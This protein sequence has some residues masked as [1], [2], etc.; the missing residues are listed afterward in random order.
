[1]EPGTS[2]R[3]GIAEDF[4]R[5]G[6]VLVPGVFEEAE[7]LELAEHVLHVRQPP[8]ELLAKYNVEGFDLNGYQSLADF[9]PQ[10]ISRVSRMLRLHL[11]D[12]RTRAL[13]LDPRLFDLM[14]ALWP[15]E[16]LA[17]HALYFPKPPGGRGLAL[18]SDLSYLPVDP[19]DLAGCFIAVDEIDAENGAL[20]VVPGSHRIADFERRVITYDESIVPEEFV[21]PAGTELVTVAMHPGDV[22]LFHGGCLHGSRPNRRRDRWRRAFTCHYVSGAARSVSE[23]LNPA[24]RS[25]G[26]EIPAPGNLT[27]AHPR[28]NPTSA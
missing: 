19:P 25:T 28:M 14:R 3:S 18:H 8:P 13:M 6:F 21:Q 7:L 1:M 26:E 12:D 9:E 11:F 15:G 2:E 23:H 20:Q 5:D 10:E 16:P 22:L 17:V 4:H 24:F 27:V